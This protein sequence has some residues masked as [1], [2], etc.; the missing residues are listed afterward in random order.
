MNETIP[1]EWNAIPGARGCTPQACSFRDNISDLRKLGVSQ[2]FGISTQ[3]P[4]Y[5]A[6]VHERLHLPYDLLSDE[7]CEF[8]KALNLPTFEWEGTSLLKRSSIAVKD[9]KVVK[10][11]YPVFP[12]DRGVIDVIEWLNTEQK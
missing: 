12:S 3:S 7:H 10:S 6:E 11:F 2:V 1:D 8:Q 4:A 9:G 5:Q